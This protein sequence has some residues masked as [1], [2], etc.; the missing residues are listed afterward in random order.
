MKEYLII[1]NKD[2][3]IPSNEIDKI[4]GFIDG[5]FEDSLTYGFNSSKKLSVVHPSKF[6]RYFA[7]NLLDDSLSEIEFSKA[8]VIS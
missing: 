2:L 3:S 8:R 4:I 5:I 6:N 7:Y 1:N